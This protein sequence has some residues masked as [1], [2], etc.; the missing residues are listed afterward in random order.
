MK[1]REEYLNEGLS[2]IEILNHAYDEVPPLKELYD[3]TKYGLYQV[4]PYRGIGGGEYPPEGRGFD[5]YRDGEPE[6]YWWKKDPG[7]DW[8]LK[9]DKK[10]AARAIKPGIE[11]EY[12]YTDSK[13]EL[14]DWTR[15]KL[16]NDYTII[17]CKDTQSGR[18]QD[19]SPIKTESL[20]EDKDLFDEAIGGYKRCSIDLIPETPKKKGKKK[21]MPINNFEFESVDLE[22][23]VVK[24][25]D[26]TWSNKGDEGKH[27]K[28]KTK[29]AAKDQTAAIF[30]NGWKPKSKKESLD[31]E[32][33]EDWYNEMFAVFIEPK[34]PAAPDIAPEEEPGDELVDDWYAEEIETESLTEGKEFDLNKYQSD[35]VPTKDDY[36]EILPGDIVEY[37]SEESEHPKG[38]GGKVLYA[39][40]YPEEDEK[41]KDKD[42]MPRAEGAKEGDYLVVDTEFEG[43]EEIPVEDVHLAMVESVQEPVEEAVEPAEDEDFTETETQIDDN[44]YYSETDGYYHIKGFD[45]DFVSYEEADAWLN[46]KD[47]SVI[48]RALYK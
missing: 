17:R 20:E 30:A 34:H 45:G 48:N 23:K 14:K 9:S 38:M 4:D 35:E 21:M 42:M 11:P 31:E 36:K 39:V 41:K 46:E 25:A 18:F 1:I 28:F 3:K 22:E 24:N 7:D 13:S 26:G 16:V 32:L 6:E 15:E 2:D 8:T 40:S 29:K 27:G 47:E 10:Y 19:Y 12:F 37:K 44:I 33:C 43:K 5:F